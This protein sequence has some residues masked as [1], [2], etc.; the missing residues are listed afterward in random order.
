MNAAATQSHRPM[1]ASDHPDAVH[2]D[3]NGFFPN[4]SNFVVAGGKFSSVTNY[5]TNGASGST[6]FKCIPLGDVDLRH[7]IR[8]SNMAGIVYRIPTSRKVYAARIEGRTSDM[9]VGIYLG[10]NAEN[11]WKNNI[12]KYDGLRHPNIAQVYGTV[13]SSGLY[14]TIYYGDLMPIQQFFWSHRSSPILTVYLHGYF[15]I[16]FAE[17]TKY[18]QS[19]SRP[20]L[21]SASYTPWIRVSTGGLCIDLEPCNTN[22][23]I[24]PYTLSDDLSRTPI[25]L[26]GPDKEATIISSVT[27]D[28]FHEICYWFLSKM[29]DYALDR[30]MLV[31]LGGIARLDSASSQNP[32][33]IAH[34]PDCNIFRDSGWRQRRACVETVENLMCLENGWTRVRYSGRL[35]LYRTVSVADAMGFWWLVQANSVLRHLKGTTS[36][37]DIVFASSVHYALEIDADEL[38]EG[39]IFLCPLEHLGA[40]EPSQFRRPECPAY[41]A[42]DPSGRE[43]KTRL[44]PALFKAEIWG[45]TWDETV[46]SGLRKF[47]A[48]KGFDPESKD[49]A[50][51]LGMPLYQLSSAGSEVSKQRLLVAT[52]LAIAGISA[53]SFAYYMVSCR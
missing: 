8:L 4:G 27:L 43:N 6:D 23:V 36:Y 10:S 30:D 14:A 7:E 47:H 1:A 18:V 2:P 17:V 13:T 42:R 3:S 25:T 44:R 48:G 20:R 22:Q 31:L 9:T 37:N 50:L 15:G 49:V 39:Y 28:H 51:H 46:Y 53:I 32:L 21:T 5:I 38:T 19:I 16:A 40:G 29:D 26:L 34:V 24:Y 11:E 41:W 52:A 35:S 33:E 12:T 45:W